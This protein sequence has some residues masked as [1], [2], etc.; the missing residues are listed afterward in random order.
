MQAQSENC[1][2]R[3]HKASVKFFTK[4]GTKAIYSKNK[5]NKLF[6]RRLTD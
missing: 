5:I 3:I 2:M 1:D 4:K 6:A